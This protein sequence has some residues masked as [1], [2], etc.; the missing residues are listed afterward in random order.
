MPNDVLLSVI[1]PVYNER[2]TVRRLLDRVRAVP[3]RKEVI[4]VDDASTDGTSEILRELAAGGDGDPMNRL[5]VFHHQR[6]A[7]K[8][9]A[10]RTGIEQ[11]SGDIALI[12]DADLEYNP[13]EYPALIA[14]IV[15][16]RADVVFGSRFLGGVHR[17]LFFRHAMG[18][19]LLTFLSNLCTDLN[20]TDMET[21][22]KVFRADVLRRLHLTSNR[23]GIEPEITAKVARLGCRVYEVPISYH[24]REYWEGKKIGWRDGFTAVWTIL[25]HALLDDLARVDA[26][27]RSMRRLHSMRRYHE[28]VW[29]RLSPYVGDRVLEAGNALGTYTRFLRQRPHVVVAD[30]DAQSVK[31]LRSSYE[32]FDNMEVRHLDWNDPALGGLAE[33]RFDTVLCLNTLE[34]LEDDDRALDSLI[35][36]LAP[37]GR[38]VL[39]VPALHRLYGEL[40]RACGYQRRYE[41]E[42]IEQK[43]RARGLELEE[44]GYFNV[45]GAFLWYLDSRVLGRRTVSP[46]RTR[47]AHLA[48][49]WLRREKTLRPRWGMGL[50]AA[51]RKPA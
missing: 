35:G 36:L 4:V 31:I 11:L 40:D 7:G 8:G 17:V 3:I 6:N 44:L 26:E 29:T 24:G 5:R 47:L 15:E 33:R 32:R 10:I 45:P 43:L 23:F 22:Y 16:G 25:R 38:L 50:L 19:S 12:Q 21:C 30:S 13:A 14:P 48:L 37:G 27:Y 49:P 41:C 51:A 9:A 46:S 42:E 28:C 20:L 34:H 39:Y 2:V 18:N 1:V